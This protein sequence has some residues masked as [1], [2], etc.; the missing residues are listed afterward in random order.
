MS[1]IPSPAQATGRR[2]DR[3]GT[4][5]MAF[6]RSFAAPTE[7]VWAA[8][9][10]P[11]RLERWTGTWAGDPASGEIAFRMTAEGEDV[12]EETFLIVECR[13]PARLSMRSAR[14]DDPTLLWR[15]QIDLSAFGGVTTLTFAQ[16]VCDVTTVESVGPGWSHLDRLVAVETGDDLDAIS[17]DSYHPGLAAYHRAEL[18]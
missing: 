6:Q 17:F 9:T 13:E 11:K 4:T 3:G 1:T 7:D 15:W 10:E 12:P 14:P 16:E 5:S 8:L 18:S 2:D